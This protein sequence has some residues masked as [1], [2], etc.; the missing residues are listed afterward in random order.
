M[1]E[2]V[3]EERNGFLLDIQNLTRTAIGESIAEK[4]EMLKSDSG[5]LERMSIA[6]EAIAREKFDINVRNERLK[7]VY[8][9]I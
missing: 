9:A 2:I 6:S 1:P 5:L 7:K 4:I 8:D 3:E